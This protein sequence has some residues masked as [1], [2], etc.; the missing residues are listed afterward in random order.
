MVSEIDFEPAQAGTLKI[1]GKE[2]AAIGVCC[3][4]TEYQDPR[5]NSARRSR[6]YDEGLL[7]MASI[8]RKSLKNS[9]SE[10]LN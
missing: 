8:R 10:K 1:L 2:A 7:F 4:L 3:K 5:S 6:L 9:E